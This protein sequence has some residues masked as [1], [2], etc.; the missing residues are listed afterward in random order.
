MYGCSSGGWFPGCSY[1]LMKTIDGGITWEYIDLPINMDLNA[2]CF[3]PE[4]QGCLVGDRGVIFNTKNWD[5]PWNLGSE[6]N[7]IWFNDIDFPDN[8]NGWAVGSESQNSMWPGQ[9]SII[10]HTSDGGNTW[11]KQNNIIE[12]YL[13]SVS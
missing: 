8:S 11:S 1:Y 2:F 3:T 6:G 10:I 12:G 7:N 9:G 5:D 4:G 13:Q